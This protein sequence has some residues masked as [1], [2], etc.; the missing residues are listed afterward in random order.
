MMEAK[1]FG[2]PDIYSESADHERAMQVANVLIDMGMKDSVVQAGYLSRAYLQSSYDFTANKGNFSD[3]VL[4]ILS[5]LQSLAIIDELHEKKQRD[6]EKLRMMLLAMVKDIRVVM[7][8]LALQLVSM[9]HIDSFVEAEQVQ[10]ALQ[11][12]DIFAPLANRLGIAKIKWELEDLSLRKLEPI[13]YRLIASSLAEQRYQREDYVKSVVAKLN[14][15]L[16]AEG[17]E[18]AKI[19]GRA[20]H[21]NSIYTKM[22]RKNKRLEEIYDLIALR[23]QVKNLTACY[24]VLGI[25]HTL[26]KHIPSE[27]DDYIANP[28]PNG[29]QSLHTAVVEP[30]DKT[31]EIQIR[32]DEMHEFA[33]LG[34]AAHWRYKE[35]SQKASAFDQQI[36]WLRHLLDEHDDTLAEEFETEIGEDRVYVIT[37]Q[38]QVVDLPQGATPL[39]FAY[40]IHTDLGHRCRGAM[41][42]GKLVPITYRLKTGEHVEILTTAK[43]QPS[44][45]W[46]NTNLG[47]LKTPR[48]RA[49]VRHFFKQLERDKAVSEGKETLDQSLQK[50]DI[51]IDDKKLGQVVERFNF[52]SADDLYASIGFGDTNVSAVVHFLEDISIDRSQQSFDDIK[53]RLARLPI[54][55]K[56]SAKGN[57]IIS[58]VSDLLTSMASCCNPIA[59]DKIGGYITKTKGV[60]IHR[61]SC[62]NYLALIA[63]EP[64]KAIDVYWSESHQGFTTTIN[65]HALDRVG[66]LRD[67]S[68]VLHNEHV[69]IYSANLGRDEDLIA[70]IQMQILVE[71]STI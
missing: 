15:S 52:K 30:E 40:L 61:K 19:Y 39:D 67:I 32:T 70:T 7:V 62:K 41:I 27:F 34:V 69:V 55:N 18:G 60:S 23:V 3:E 10:L 5:D 25:V 9:R 71:I 56:K 21:I 12:K 43:I 28:K 26:W 20:K 46:L 33:E 51:K 14:E 47:Y 22:K 13:T 50:V 42:N 53:T 44:R 24:T 48:A 2:Y 68:Q 37:P 29:Y 45:D 35:Q 66:L 38:G 6:I 17:I 54:R 65:I 64:D 1:D 4:G 59:P 31:I 16:I 8:K 63:A 11:T 57:V 49:K 58:G 36:N